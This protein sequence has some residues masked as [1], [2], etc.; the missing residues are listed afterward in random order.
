MKHN[1]QMM[2]EILTDQ[3]GI[4]DNSTNEQ[5]IIKNNIDNTPFVAVQA[6]NEWWLGYG[7]FRL[8]PKLNTEDEVIQYLIEE[9]WNL[10]A[11]VAGIIAE[12][13]YQFNRLKEVTDE[14]ENSL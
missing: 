10:I 4:K 3:L 13:V 2:K 1:E 11:V 14:K 9:Q 12:K 6:N 7:M 8:S 5:L